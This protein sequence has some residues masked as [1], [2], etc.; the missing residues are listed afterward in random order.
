MNSTSLGTAHIASSLIALCFICDFG[1]A[2]S[3]VKTIV[4]EVSRNFDTSPFV[5]QVFFTGRIKK[6]NHLNA[7]REVSKKMSF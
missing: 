4:F 5:F 3:S 2:L 7:G 6:S 1:I